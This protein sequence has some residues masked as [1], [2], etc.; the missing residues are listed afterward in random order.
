MKLTAS[1]MLY[2]PLGIMLVVWGIIMLLIAI[3]GFTV[4]I[5]NMLLMTLQAS[6]GC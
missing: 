4:T 3:T 1:N 2:K 5:W 6:Y